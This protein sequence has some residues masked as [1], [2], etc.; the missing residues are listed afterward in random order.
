MLVVVVLHYCYYGVFLFF[1]LHIGTLQTESFLILS[2][3]FCRDSFSSGALFS[4]KTSTFYLGN[5][6]QNDPSA[7]TPSNTFFFYLYGPPTL[8]F[9][10]CPFGVSLVRLSILLYRWGSHLQPAPIGHMPPTSTSRAFFFLMIWGQPLLCGAVRR[11]VALIMALP[12][13]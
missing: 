8:L 5:L 10:G 11:T 6:L 12:A 7:C 3:K 2:V 1:C 4:H 9:L 13:H